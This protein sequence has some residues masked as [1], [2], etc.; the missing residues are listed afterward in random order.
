MRKNQVERNSPKPDKINYNNINK[1]NP[2]KNKNMAQ[3]LLNSMM[4][5]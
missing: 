1:M 4:W 3:T 5:L 2:T